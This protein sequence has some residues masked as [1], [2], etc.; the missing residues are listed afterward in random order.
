MLAFIRY[1]I[2]SF[3]RSMTFIPPAVIFFAWI[4][5][6]YAY[7]NAPI[8]SSYGVSSIALYLCMTWITMAIFRLEEE[9][10]KHILFTHL[11]GKMKF[12][13][14]KWLT[15]LISML[16]LALFSILYPLVTSSFH[17][18]MTISLFTMTVYSHMI[19]AIFGVIVGTFFSATVLAMKKYAWLSAVFALVVSLAAKSLLETFEPLKWILWIFPPIFSV[20]EHMGDVDLIIIGQGF[21][22]DLMITLVYVVGFSCLTLLLFLKRER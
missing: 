7:K 19:F 14:G 4:F 21:F 8:L 15:A 10:E 9:S 17:G 11:C 1:Q 16:P 5:I 20:I 2:I 3:I 12:F 18:E 22:V 13:I 6:L